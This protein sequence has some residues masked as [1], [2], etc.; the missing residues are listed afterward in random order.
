M[1]AKVTTFVLQPLGWFS[2]L[3]GL[4]TSIYF[5]CSIIDSRSF[6]TVPGF[7]SEDSEHGYAR[8]FISANW[9]DFLSTP[10][11]RIERFSVGLSNE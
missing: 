5:H 7:H 4:E 3:R 1:V 6:T 10:S 11:V 2:G 9:E 8:V